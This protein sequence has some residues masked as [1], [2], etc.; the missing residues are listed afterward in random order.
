MKIVGKISF[1]QGPLSRDPEGMGRDD[2]FERVLIL[3][4]L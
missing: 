4:Y 3:S 2:A 1:P